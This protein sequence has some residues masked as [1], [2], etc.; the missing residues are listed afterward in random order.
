MEEATRSGLAPRRVARLPHPLPHA[1]VELVGV[2]AIEL[3]S[4]A[5]LRMQEQRHQQGPR[6]QPPD[7]RPPGDPA[8]VVHDDL[9]PQEG[10]ELFNDLK[11]DGKK[12]EEASEPVL[13]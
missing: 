6:Q 12:E 5:P 4:L 3:L 9:T 1:V 8:G 10:L 7:V 13:N 11:S 2:G